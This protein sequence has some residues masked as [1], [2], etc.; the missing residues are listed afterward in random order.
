[1]ADNKEDF[2]TS[3]LTALETDAVVE[4]FRLIFEPIFTGILD[5]YTR[6]MGD[7]ITKLTHTVEALKKGSAEKDN[8]IVTLQ[9]Q[10]TEMETKLDDLEQHGRRDSIRI[11][12][13]S[14]A[15]SGTTDDKV[16]RL[17]NQRMQISPPLTI[18][19][20]SVSHR[21]GKPGEPDAN[22]TPPP[23]RPLLVRFATRRSRNRVISERKKLRRTP[24]AAPNG[25]DE[26]PRQPLQESSQDSTGVGD[27]TDDNDE[28]S[29]VDNAWRQDGEKIYISD[30]LTKRKATL[31]YRAR[32][33]K[34]NGG[35]LDT[36]VYDC[37]VMIKDRYGR[38]TVIKD[39]SELQD[40]IRQ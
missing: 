26:L 9:R 10:V 24:T 39:E 22:G 8:Q 13:L 38:I 28:I 23:P 19:E 12:G 4:R 21:V 3:L 7:A 27:A 5:P 40:K 20:I 36:W 32:M 37:K 29:S 14:E 30:D 2:V 34:R 25:R 33:A 1:M 17:C 18:D 16:L 15:S 35:L 6:K 11:F 31:A